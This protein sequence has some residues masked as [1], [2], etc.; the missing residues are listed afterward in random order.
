MGWFFRSF[1]RAADI[2]GIAR[3]NKPQRISNS[4]PT[5]TP[6]VSA[7]SNKTSRDSDFSTSVAS[8]LLNLHVSIPR[9]GESEFRRHT[10]SCLNTYLGKIVSIPRRGESEIRRGRLRVKP[11]MTAADSIPRRGESEFRPSPSFGHQFN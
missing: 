4:L 6:M 3:D 10:S 7:I 2:A 9:R 8:I 1:S 11:A 5:S